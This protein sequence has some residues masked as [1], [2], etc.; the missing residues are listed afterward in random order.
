M[1]SDTILKNPFKKPGPLPLSMF[2]PKGDPLGWVSEQ[3]DPRYK[4]GR[5]SMLVM[6]DAEWWA[7]P[8]GPAHVYQHCKLCNPSGCPPPPFKSCYHG[9]VMT[10]AWMEEYMRRKKEQF[11]SWQ[12]IA[13]GGVLIGGGIIASA[14]CFVLFFIVH[15]VQMRIYAWYLR[16]LKGDV[17]NDHIPEMERAGQWHPYKPRHRDA[18]WAARQRGEAFFPTI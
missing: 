13:T 18:A 7:K 3:E 11:W 15:Y 4:G 1:N 2:E 9:F 14:V 5:P 8:D 10:A 12:I 17:P 6:T 16:A